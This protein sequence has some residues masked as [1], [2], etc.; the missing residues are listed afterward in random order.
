MNKLSMIADKRATKRCMRR[1]PV[2]PGALAEAAAYQEGWKC[3]R[4]P[5]GLIDENP[6]SRWTKLRKV[7]NEGWIDGGAIY[8]PE[9]KPAYED[10]K[11]KLWE[12]LPGSG[13]LLHGGS[14]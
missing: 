4:S 6:H 13:I 2:G 9:S 3:G 7:W 12:L 1:K 14:V 11:R 10:P 5:T 8:L